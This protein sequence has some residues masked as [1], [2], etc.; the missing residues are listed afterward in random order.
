[1]SKH[2]HKSVVA[3]TDDKQASEDAIS[4]A[5]KRAQQAQHL[6]KTAQKEIPELSGV[7][8]IKDNQLFKQEDKS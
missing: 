2:T 3:S 4:S 1:M 5:A 6:I 8:K 7:F